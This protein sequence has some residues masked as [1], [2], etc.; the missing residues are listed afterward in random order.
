MKA[1]A[2]AAIAAASFITPAV[3]GQMD[4]DTVSAGRYQA[5]LGDCQACHTRP[6]GKPFAGGAPLETPFGKLVPPNIT[7][8][9][10]TGIGNWTEADFQRMMKKGV[11]HR[12]VRLYPAM[13]YPAYSKMP[14]KDIADLWAYM[15]TVQPVVNEVKSNQL[16]FPFNIRAVMIGWNWINF[17]G[18][19]FKPDPNKSD[20]WNRGAYIVNGPG[21]CGTCHTPKTFMGADKQ[22][23]ALTGASLQGWFAPN[24]TGDKRIGIG[25]W[26]DEELSAYLKTGRNSYGRASGPMAEAIEA[27]TSKMTDAD[28]KAIVTYLKDSAASSGSATAPQPA[29]A[30]DPHMK[31]GAAIYAVSCSACHGSDGKGE[32]NMFPS[33]AGNPAVMQSGTETLAR[34][35]LAGTQAAYTAAAPTSPAMPSFAWR[36]NDQQTADLLTYIR[37]SWG[38]AAAPVASGD[39]SKARSLLRDGS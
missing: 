33:L 30:D 26:S 17:D 2:I 25:G 11:G 39:V 24:I 34:V 20:L 14:D 16:P 3:A 37:N 23:L 18:A 8:D 19:P 4:F 22:K 28:I 35:V 12:G 5:I 6:G 13:P 9:P 10:T 38:N 7:P 21:H 36:L 29:S 1:L 27:S 15:R 32:K 31:A